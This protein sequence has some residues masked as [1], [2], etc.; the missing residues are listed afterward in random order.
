[1]RL[2]K[3]EVVFPSGGISLAGTLTLPANASSSPFVIMVHGSGA[4]DR[5]GNMSGF[6]VQTFKFLAEHLAATGIAVFRYDKRGCAQSG[7]SF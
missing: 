4:Q 3:E 6:N 1:M 2:R 7:E 5:D